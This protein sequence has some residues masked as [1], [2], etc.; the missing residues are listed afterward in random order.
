MLFKT[1]P[2]L[3]FATC[4]W[5]KRMRHLLRHFSF[6]P[7]GGKWLLL[8]FYH[9]PATENET[10]VHRGAM[11]QRHEWWKWCDM[12][13]SE[14]MEGETEAR[15]RI[16]VVNSGKYDIPNCSLL[17][18]T[19]NSLHIFFYDLFFASLLCQGHVCENNP[20]ILVSAFLIFLRSLWDFLI[21]KQNTLALPKKLSVTR[22]EG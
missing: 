4:W 19:K 1:A 9:S 15:A 16:C 8:K 12:C 13:G 17:S 3:F 14:K 11:P 7:A 21:T 2:M 22:R 5:E 10:T 18:P 20:A 6:P